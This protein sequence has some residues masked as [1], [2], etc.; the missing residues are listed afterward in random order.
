M[1]SEQLWGEGEHARLEDITV[2]LPHPDATA[3]IL[4]G[5]TEI[6]AHFTSPPFQQQQLQNP[7]ARRV[8]S[9]YDVLGGP[10]TAVVLWATSAYRDANP[11]TYAPSSRRSTRPRP[12]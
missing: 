4:S 6:T 1:A 2:T 3:A 10:G 8:L 11:G 12:S 7:N 9:S 5:G